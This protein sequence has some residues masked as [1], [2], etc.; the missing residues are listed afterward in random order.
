VVLLTANKGENGIE[1]E[2]FSLEG[3]YF[4]LYNTRGKWLRS[5]DGTTKLKLASELYFRDAGLGLKSLGLTD[6][7]RGFKG[8]V[9]LTAA[10]NNI[11]FP[12]DKN[13]FEIASEGSLAKGQLKDFD[14]AVLKIVNLFTLNLL[15][16]DKDSLE[17]EKL[18]GKVHYSKDKA[19]FKTLDFE[20][21]ATKV[22]WDGSLDLKDMKLDSRVTTELRLGRAISLIALGSLNPA[23]AIGYLGSGKKEFEIGALNKLTRFKYD[24]KGAVKEP[25]ISV[26]GYSL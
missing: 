3:G 2:D 25:K 21:A 10:G 16:F 14:P 9:Q 26:I 24:I 15:E 4:S 6:L 1:I 19:I 17:I 22:E 23:L 18:R 11:Q 7:V 5:K 20:L 13:Q 8:G 12:F